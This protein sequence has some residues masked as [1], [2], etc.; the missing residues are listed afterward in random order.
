M[1]TQEGV[2]APYFMIYSQKLG[3][4]SDPYAT[5]TLNLEFPKYTILEK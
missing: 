1:E 3:L 2:Y 4:S 5:R